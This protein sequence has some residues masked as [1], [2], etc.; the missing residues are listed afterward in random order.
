MRYC[1]PRLYDKTHGKDCVFR[2]I[3]ISFEVTVFVGFAIMT[4]EV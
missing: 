4:F 1:F 2:P 3:R